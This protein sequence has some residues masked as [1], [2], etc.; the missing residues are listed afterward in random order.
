MAGLAIRTSVDGVDHLVQQLQGLNRTLRNRVSRRIAVAASKAVAT[1]AKSFAPRGTGTLQRS[2]GVVIRTYGGVNHRRFVGVIGA[3]SGYLKGRGFKLAQR[4][5]DRG[6]RNIGAAV[7]QHLVIGGTR[8][9][10]LNKGAR[11]IRKS[12]VSTGR[13]IRVGEAL[14]MSTGVIGKRKMHPG[15]RPNPFL[16]RAL[17]ASKSQAFDAAKREFANGLS[18]TKR[19]IAV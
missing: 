6:K 5:T 16:Q 2:Q 19:G 1:A 12:K 15:A 10:F 14:R 17:Q 11:L 9:H 18:E 13:V 8:P 7:Y 4:E 3:R